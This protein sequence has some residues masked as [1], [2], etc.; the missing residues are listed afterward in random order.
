MYESYPFFYASLC[1]VINRYTSFI[2]Y[3]FKG[4]ADSLLQIL[5]INFGMSTSCGVLLNVNIRKVCSKLHPATLEM[6]DLTK[7][8]GLG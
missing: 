1:V 8:S 5:P 6:S 4:V 2:E 3:L 7:L